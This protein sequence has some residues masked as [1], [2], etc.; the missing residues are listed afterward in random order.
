YSNRN[1]W[2]P[3]DKININFMLS[4]KTNQQPD[5]FPVVL[6]LL[7]ANGRV[8]YKTVNNAPKG[9]IWAFEVSTDVADATGF[10]TATVKV[11]NQKFSKMLR[12][13]TVKPNRLKIDFQLPELIS[14]PKH[15][16]VKLKSQ[17]LN[18]LNASNLSATIDVSLKNGKTQF[19]NFPQYSFDNESSE[20][21]GST[22]SL[23]SSKLSSD[24]SKMVSFQPLQ[25]VSAPGFLN[26]VFTTKVFETNGDFS[27]A[28]QTSKIS[29]YQ[30]Y[31]GVALPET[32]SKYGNYYFTDEEWNF[33]VAVVDENGKLSS[34]DVELEGNIYQL[35]DYWW[36]NNDQ[37]ELGKYA[38]G[39]YK[40]PVKTFSIA[41]KNGKGAFRLRF[42]DKEWGAYLM[43]IEDKE[44]GHVFSKVINFDVSN[45]AFRSNNV[46][47][48]PA[49]IGL[50]SDKTTYK[51]GD[52]M[53]FSFPANSDA[54]A[55]ITVESASNVLQTIVLESLSEDE[56]VSI[57]AT[58]EMVPNVYVYVSLIQPYNKKNDLPLRM[59]GVAA[60][61]VVDET[62]L[63][64]PTISM[65][66]TTESNKEIEIKVSE[67]EGRA[68]YY[69]LALVD[70]GILGLTNYKTPDPYGH[71]FSKQ[72]LNVRTWD[73][74]NDVI[75]V[76]TGEL[77]SVF[78]V[79]GDLSIVNQDAL[80]LERFSSVA[81]M[82]GSF[83]LE[84]GKTASHQVKIPEY[85][86]SLRA[87]VVAT[88]GKGAFGSAQK[89]IAVKD[90][91]MLIPTAPRVVSPKDR[92]SIPL[93]ILAPELKNK[94]VTL[95]IAA[96]NLNIVNNPTIS[97]KINNEGEAMVNVEVA[98]PETTGSACLSITATAGSV[99]K[100]TE[101]VIPIRVPYSPKHQ[102]VTE[103]IAPK[104]TKTINMNVQGIAGTLNGDLTINAAIPVDLFRRLDMLIDYPHGCLE[105][106]VSKGFPQLYLDDLVGLDETTKVE[107]K[108]NI[109]VAIS[110]MKSYLRSDYSMTNWIGGNYVTP[111]TELYAA[112]FLIEAKMKGYA[113]SDEMLKNIIK[114]QATKANAWRYNSD[115]PSDETIQAYRLF[116]LSLNN[117]AAIGAMNRFKSL[118]TKYPLT[119]ALL[120]SAYAMVGK[121]KT[122]EEI[123]PV[124]DLTSSKMESDWYTSYGSKTRDLAMMTYAKM[125][126][127]GN[128]DYVKQYINQI[129][130][131]LGSNQYMCT[132]TTAFSLFVLGKYAEMNGYKNT[133]VS[134]TATVNGKEK[135]FNTNLPFGTYSFVPQNGNNVIAV[136]NNSDAAI[137]ASVYTKGTVAEYETVE[138]G[139]WYKMSVNYYDKS[140]KK[141]D[142]KKLA[143]NTDFYVKIEVENPSQYPVTENA[144]SYLTPSGW[145]IINDRIFSDNDYRQSKYNF[146][147]IRDDRVCFYFDLAP[148]EKKSFTVSLNATYSGS[149]T[150]PAVHCEDMYNDEIYYIIPAKAVVV[151]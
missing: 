18:G 33:D 126:T 125:L 89:N 38:R 34:S 144:L 3:G 32:K 45:N 128:S 109:E 76:F 64:H 107:M 134:A 146:I 72:A 78:A 84:K 95:S 110:K 81:F 11:G 65:P 115:Y 94:E 50:K 122:A 145:E 60:V 77:N 26:A 7:D 140:N 147:D 66:K 21:Y 53:I 54:K 135:A 127:D 23:F 13:E 75:D 27:I 47:D 114:Y 106:T 141:I 31:V 67:N 1:V 123:L 88:D 99:S 62:T 2:R 117:T 87:M 91:M 58:K 118:Q 73:N 139:N 138:K 74:Y 85:F 130:K 48:A 120:A 104:T 17:W 59:Y 9:K 63:L 70:E 61:T 69:T 112:H 25:S 52:K 97:A 43:V 82:L 14:L 10:W 49:I 42:S 28:T 15:Q 12:V 129:C 35:D 101:I 132:Q 24:G 19:K 93:Q 6:E 57:T 40:K 80:L 8:R 116:V 41:C 148:N 86:G 22:T 143:R 46:G 121:K 44:Y 4:D 136:T 37:N 29:P 51:V 20:F 39:T 98:V 55:L 16:E 79:G 150:I 133:S 131:V 149:F 96:K 71:F 113:V 105:Q 111:W 137:F 108:N 30:R 36:W 90:P 68:M 5:N 83:K 100:K 92:L 119:K 102:M 103:E 151:E 56:I 142:P 124:I